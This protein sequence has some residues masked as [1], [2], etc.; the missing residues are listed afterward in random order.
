[1]R[2][3]SLLWV[4]VA[5]CLSAWGC[6]SE[7]RTEASAA[8][9][10]KTAAEPAKTAAEPA[11]TAEPAKG[12]G[13]A[14]ETEQ[15]PAG[16]VA[17]PA[18]KFWM[19]C[20]PDQDSECAADEKPGRRVHLDEYYIDRTEVTV[21]R[22]TDCVQAGK[23]TPA[24]TDKSNENMYNWGKPNRKA[25]PINGVSWHQ[26][27]AYCA[28]AGKRLPTEAEWEKAARGTDGRKYPW[29]KEFKESLMFMLNQSE[30]AD[31]PPYEA[32]WPVCVMDKKVKNAHGL[33]DM[34]GNLWEWVA[35][36][37]AKDY[38]ETAPE[39]NPP[40]PASG[41]SRVKRGGSFN[42]EPKTFRASGRS[43]DDPG[44][45]F[46]DDGFRCAWSAAR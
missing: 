35:D 10:A 4:L 33:C 46:I 31:D 30:G 5:V 18:G 9:P 37:Y 40:G 44:G 14:A 24:K 45:S 41:K 32:T 17:I 12:E 8:E 28:W 1:M 16:M 25:H 23:C 20:K 11:K 7:K 3:E 39:K 42:N 38:Y 26:A 27:S 43:Y 21:A 36:Y 15:P 6:K 29:G 22:Y 34:G 13:Q 19:G 2:C